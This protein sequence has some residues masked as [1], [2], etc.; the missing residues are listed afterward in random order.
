M[1][2]SIRSAWILAR[3]RPRES[4]RPRPPTTVGTPAVAQ[5]GVQDEDLDVG[6]RLHVIPVVGD[7]RRLPV[8]V[9][10]HCGHGGIVEVGPDG[11]VRLDGRVV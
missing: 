7:G 10:G 3:P 1:T 11:S 6:T 2:A 5:R 8:P 9:R 4:P